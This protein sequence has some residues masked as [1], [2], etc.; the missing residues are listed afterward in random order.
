MAL[1]ARMRKVCTCALLVRDLY[2]ASETA[3]SK[4]K[5]NSVQMATIVNIDLGYKIT[6]FNESHAG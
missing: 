3:E 1:Q 2:H 4:E 6:I 5:T